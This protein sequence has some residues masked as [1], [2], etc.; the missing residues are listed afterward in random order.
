MA[1]YQLGK[2]DDV[3]KSALYSMKFADDFQMDAPL[4]QFG[5]EVWF[6]DKLTNLCYDALGIPAAT[7]RGLFE[8]IYKADSLTLYPH[9]PP[10]I[11]EYRQKEPIRFGTKC[12]FISVKNG[13]PRVKSLR[14][15]SRKWE[16][17]ATDHVTLPYDALPEEAKIEIVTDGLPACPELACGEL[18]EPVEGV[19]PTGRWGDG[20]SERNASSSGDLPESLAEPR[21]ILGEMKKLIS[22]EP[23]ADYERAFLSEAIRSMESYRE[24]QARDAQGI[25]GSFSQEKRSAILTMYEKAALSLYSGFDNLMKRYSGGDERQRRMARLY[26]DAH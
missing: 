13:G 1:Y 24:R 2:Y 7:A 25:Y 4:P 17:G 18:V 23:G 16:A 15:N 5:K 3:R 20:E 14:V 26:A 12:L 11:L 8:Y 9:I 21:R 6:K 22:N 10:G 19:K